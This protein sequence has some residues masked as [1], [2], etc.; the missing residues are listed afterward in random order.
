MTHPAVELEED[1]D[2]DDVP[3]PDDGN[4]EMEIGDDAILPDELKEDFVEGAEEEEIQ[5][6]EFLLQDEDENDNAQVIL[7]E[8]LVADFD[9]PIEED[10]KEIILPA[11][12]ILPALS[13]DEEC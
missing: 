3:L 13:S 1:A 11:D 10:P 4:A 6:I 12:E 7:F 2:D 8:G 9:E 5:Y